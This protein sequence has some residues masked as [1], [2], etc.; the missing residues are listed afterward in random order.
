MED[1]YNYNVTPEPHNPIG[2][3][4]AVIL[5]MLF[6]A[7][8]GSCRAPQSTVSERV[9]YDTVWTEKVAQNAKNDS[10]V[11]RE[12][13]VVQPHVIRVGDTTIVYSDTTIVRV[14][15]NNHYVTRNIYQDQGKIRV[16]TAYK[17]EIQYVTKNTA[18]KDTSAKWR[19]LWAGIAIGILLML[20][21]KHRNTLVCLFRRLA[22][23]LS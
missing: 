6:C 20:L 5:A 13:I 14:A 9:V 1:I 3:L 18:V 2:C 19:A 15:E 12:K 7:I 4:I 17:K 23:R 16:D 11:Y 8:I 21:Y 10:I 22:K